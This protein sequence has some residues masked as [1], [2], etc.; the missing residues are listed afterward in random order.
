MAFEII[1]QKEEP[2]LSRAKV[3]A[4]ITFEQATPSNKDVKKQ[5]ASALKK[6]ENLV[7]IKK[8]ST[9]FGSRQAEVDAYVYNSEEDMKRIE[10]KPKKK[11]EKKAPEAKAE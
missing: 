7:V 10:P 8:I 1:S 6:D 5:A 3:K 4:R 9:K 2:L 11:A